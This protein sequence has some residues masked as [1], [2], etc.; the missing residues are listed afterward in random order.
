MYTVW[1]SKLP[2]LL[3]IVALF[4][5]GFMFL[6]GSPAA[7]VPASQTPSVTSFT[8]GELPSAT[9]TLTPTLPP[10]ATPTITSSVTPTQSPSPTPEPVIVFA[11]IGDYGSGNRKARQVADLVESWQPDFIITTGDN[12][13][14]S[15][16]A[17]TIDATIGKFYHEYI[18]P[19]HGAFGDG[20]EQNRF[21]PSLGNHDWMTGGA[22]P[23]LKYFALPGNER[24]YD[25]TWGPLHLFAVDADSNEP[26][27]VG[28]SSRQADWLQAGLAEATEPWKIVYFHQSPYSSGLHGSVEWMRWPFKDWGATAVLS[29]HDHVYERLLVDGLVYFV[30]GLGG[31]NIYPFGD[32]L[33]GSKV[34]FND[35]YGAMRVE[36]TSNK[37]E[38]QFITQGGEV[39]DTYEI[40]R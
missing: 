28:R 22:S 14:P 40:E 18:S 21:F 7:E 16:S 27:G 37:I 25:F 12:N 26:D 10:S 23:Y 11:V 20:A 29:G 33:D 8:P 9:A 35:D 15:G 24:Y 34:R 5:I 31:G 39:I 36:A 38:F 4:L 19:Y 6:A 2:A 13:Y 32:R 30:N 3:L 17:E 1:R